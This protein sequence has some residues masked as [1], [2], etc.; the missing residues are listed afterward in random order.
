MSTATTQ[1]TVLFP[2]GFDARGQHEAAARGY[3][4]H[5]VARLEDG[6]FYQLVFYDVVRLQQDLADETEAGRRYLAEP[7]LIVVP[8]VT[9][10]AIKEAVLGLWQ[11]G[12]FEHLKP[13]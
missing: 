3:L 7:N 6:S 1:P 12:F 9:P 13:L 5:V 2:D 4:S 10:A 8:E 11:D